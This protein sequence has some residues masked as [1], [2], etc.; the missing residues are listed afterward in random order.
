VRSDSLAP[1]PFLRL[2]ALGAAAATAVVVAS[3]ALDLGRAHWGATLVALPLLVAVLVTALLA[4]PRLVA[5]AAVAVAA[6][7]GAVATGGVV[8][9]AD[10]ARW[11]VVLHVAV[12]GT[13]L[14]ATLV[15][16]AVSLRG[17]RV[18]LGS[19]RD[20]VTL[21]KPRIMTLL[22]LTGAAGMFVGAGGWPDPWLFLATMAGLALACGGASALNHVMDAD[23]DKLM[24]ERTAARPVAAGRV[25]APRALEFGLALSGLSFA[26]LAST[27]NVLTAV[28]ALVGNLFYVVVYTG[29]LKRSTDQNIVIGGAAGAVPPVVGYAAATGSLALPALWLFLIVF[30]WT[31]PHF[32]ALALMIKEHY[33]AADIPML[34]GTRGERETTR[35]ILLYSIVLVAFTLGVGLWLGPLYTV[36][37]GLLGAYF[38]LLAWRL[39]V[40]ASRRN[41]VVLFHYSLAYL[42]LLFVAAAVDPLVV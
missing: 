23:I 24:G 7:L 26:L 29:Y 8:A 5:P 40:D 11:A 16:L 2:S 31:P 15:T 18:P 30:L 1:G 19:W 28:L 32:W 9:W 22:L 14:A 10:S 13:A 27:V 6:M 39:R 38:L 36:A 33:A 42:A 37:A 25:A 4:Y 34:P 17:E 35:Q 21:T 12:A 41:A 3:A 20:Y